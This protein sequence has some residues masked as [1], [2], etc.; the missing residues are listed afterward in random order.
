MIRKPQ[1]FLDCD[2]V[3]ADFDKKAL[4]I[5]GM[6][7]KEFEEKHGTPRFWKWIEQ[8]NKDHGGFYS[9]LDLMEDAMELYYSVVHLDPI[10]LTGIPSNDWSA[11]QKVKW[12]ERMFGPKQRV[13]C[14]QSKKKSHYAEPG[15][16]IVD[17]TIKYKELWENAGG[18]FITHISAKN[19]LDELRKIGVI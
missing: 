2:G 8:Y 5:F 7:P 4:E 10:I 9:L 17:D 1:I 16:I 11:P 15:D 12:V 18:I 6:P 19:S 14:C 3:L 13:I